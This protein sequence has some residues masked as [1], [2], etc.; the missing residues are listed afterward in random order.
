MKINDKVKS[1]K[2]PNSPAGVVKHVDGKEV[3][4]QF[5]MRSGW[6]HVAWFEHE[7]LEVEA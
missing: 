2:F 4:V 5:V 6:T 1:R 7:E 3:A